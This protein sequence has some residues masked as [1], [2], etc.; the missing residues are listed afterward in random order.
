MRYSLTQLEFSCVGNYQTPGLYTS[1]CPNYVRVVIQIFLL[2][3][4]K[5]ALHFRESGEI[6][7]HNTIIIY[8]YYNTITLLKMVGSKLTITTDSSRY[9]ALN[10]F[11]H[12]LSFFDVNIY[13][14]RD[15]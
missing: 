10:D 2:Q 4:V 7:I 12:C 8:Y 6:H 14:C 13:S 11:L 1:N 15:S 3:N 9:S 5:E